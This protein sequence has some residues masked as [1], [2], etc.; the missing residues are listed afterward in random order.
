MN[1]D[2]KRAFIGMPLSINIR[3]DIDLLMYERVVFV[4]QVD[5]NDKKYFVY[6]L[7]KSKFKHEP[8]AV[9]YVKTDKDII[10]YPPLDFI[11]TI[12]EYYRVSLENGF[13]CHPI[14]LKLDDSNN[15]ELFLE[16]IK[17]V[18]EYVDE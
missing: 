13:A 14:I 15:Q 2:T 17:M 7:N 6:K 12:N 10:I 8:N 11:Q 9:N 4:S 3:K 18:H 5:K 16:T 1:N